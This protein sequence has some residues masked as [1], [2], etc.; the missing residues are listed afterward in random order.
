MKYVFLLFFSILSFAE[1]KMEPFRTDTIPDIEPKTFS[2]EYKPTREVHSLGL[3][4]IP[5]RVQPSNE[6]L[7]K[8]DVVIPPSFSISAFAELAPVKNQGNCGSCVSFA[9]A[10]TVE[11][12]YRIRGKIIPTLSNQYQMSCG[13]REWMCDGSLFENTASDYTLLGG[14][15][16]QAAYP[17]TASNASC[18]GKTSELVGQILSQ[19]LIDNSPKSIATALLTRHAVAV[20]VG[21]DNYWSGYSGG[22]YNACSNAGTNH[23]VE[24]VGYDCEGECN[25]DSQGKLPPGKG[26]YLIK[27]SWGNWGDN[28]Y[29]WTKITSSSGRLCNNIAE[30]A[31]IVEVDVPTPTPT[32]SPT[33][34]PT[35][36][37]PSPIHLDW[38]WIAIAVA[39]LMGLAGL[40]VAIVKKP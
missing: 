4:K 30:E 28:G 26:K 25:F 22:V 6:F 8:N 17:Y 23:Q 33:P 3:I 29:I 2:F 7:E 38:T 12:T 36:V 9:V 15:A 35:P 40:V 31:G 27:N 39:F 13:K 5:S 1:P 24:L 11:D 16:T 10:A 14:T 20:T 34:S 32:P 19:K 37:P 21:V 18:R